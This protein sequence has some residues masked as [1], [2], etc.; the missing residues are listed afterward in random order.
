MSL[1]NDR[2]ANQL[3]ATLREKA[4]I[5]RLALAN[6]PSGEAHIHAL[7]EL[8]DYLTALARDDSRLYALWLLSGYRGQDL[9]AKTYELAERE[10]GAI[11]N[12]GRPIGI[13]PNES[14]D[15]FMAAATEDTFEHL[16]RILDQEQE[17]ARRAGDLKTELDAAGQRIVELESERD[18]LRSR[19]DAAEADA[20][21]Y[22]ARTAY[23]VQMIG[24][25]R[26]VPSN[27]KEGSAPEPAPPRRERVP[28]EPYV[29]RTSRADGETV[30]EVGWRT[31]GKQHWKRVGT[32]LDA[33]RK[34]RDE[35]V[36]A[37]A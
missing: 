35:K 12:L 11:A 30:Y 10:Q 5:A 14:F 3:A 20:N 31:H 17:M 24:S 15:A 22:R 33:A 23:L 9:D 28:D 36:R 4:E 26:D 8:G 27:G 34:L 2:I 16:K 37:T 32:D 18:A 25:D 19:A 1:G 13:P 7:L 6:E 29:Y 21:D